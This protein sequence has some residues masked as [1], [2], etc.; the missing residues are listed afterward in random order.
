MYNLDFFFRLKRDANSLEYIIIFETKAVC[1]IRNRNN[2]NLKYS[3]IYSYR[4]YCG[5]LIVT[6]KE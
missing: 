3:I 4:K 1:T 6:K 5:S 2:R